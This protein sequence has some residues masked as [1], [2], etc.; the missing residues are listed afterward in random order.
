MKLRKREG[1]YQTELIWKTNSQEQWNSRY[2]KPSPP[3]LS[4]N[5]NLALI[6]IPYTYSDMRCNASCKYSK[7]N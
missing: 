1:Y 4:T 2:I 6:K 7:R 5:N 3:E